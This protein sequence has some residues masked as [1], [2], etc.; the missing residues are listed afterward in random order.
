M[1]RANELRPLDLA[2]PGGESDKKELTTN[3]ANLILDPSQ[4]STRDLTSSR[5]MKVGVA[6]V[7]VGSS[8]TR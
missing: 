1:S 3:Q 4:R 7:V 6:V 2:E 8:S 5:A